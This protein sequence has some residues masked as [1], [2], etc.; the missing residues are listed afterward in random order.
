[1]LAHDTFG[2]SQVSKATVSTD[3]STSLSESERHEIGD[4]TVTIVRSRGSCVFPYVGLWVIMLRKG[5]PRNAS[6]S[7]AVRSS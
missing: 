6:L 3:V 5:G 1:M 4:E 7:K 2:S